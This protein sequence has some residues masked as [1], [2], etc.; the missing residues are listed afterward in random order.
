MAD[1]VYGA[2]GAQLQDD[3]DDYVAGINQYI[4]RRR[5]D[6]TQDAGR[7]RRDRQAA[8]GL[9][10]HRRDR[11]RGADRR[12]LR[13]GRRQRGRQR[14]GATGSEGPI[15]A[16]PRASRCGRDFRRR[17]T[18]RRR[19]PRS[20]RQRIVPLPERARTRGRRR[21]PDEGSAR[22]TPPDSS[23]DAAPAGGGPVGGLLGGLGRLPGGASNAL[24]VSGAE[25][26]SGQPLAVFGPA[27]RLLQP[28]DPDGAWTCTAPTSTPAAPPSPG[29]SLYVLLGRGPGLRLVGDLGG[30]GHHRHLRREALRAGRLGS[31]TSHVDA[32]PL[33]GRVPADGDAHA[34]EQDHAR[35]RATRAPPETF[36]LCRPS[37]RCTGSSTSAAPSTATPVA[38]AQ[39]RST[40]F[41][42]ADSARAFVGLNQPSKVQ[43]AEDFQQVMNEINFTFNWFYADDRDIAYFNSGDNPVR[44][45]G[46]DPDLPTWGTG[47]YDW[48][49]WETT[50]QDRP[51]YTPFAE[52]PQV[53]NQDYITSLEQQA[54]AR[55]R[56]RRRPVR[57]RPDLPL[58][59]ARR[60]DRAADRRRATR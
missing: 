40:Y 46:A 33:Q 25:S 32:L 28:P 47:E 12:N 50:L 55:L 2:E 18:I 16:A 8:R 51:T 5:I 29:V 53:I 6:P 31:P 13:Q 35:T 34:G 49:G 59:V 48:Q 17:R 39:Q 57:L 22:R 38:F 15:P 41:H 24:L 1:D 3:V 21:L 36:T 30:P 26:E 43:N 4:S 20:R 11:H 19:R 27:G 44:A 7:V 23:L 58:A 10:G 42:E 60:A 9:A 14:R 37:A 54:G 45:A 52:H 56:R